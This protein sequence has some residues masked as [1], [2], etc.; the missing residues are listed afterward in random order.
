MINVK[1][2]NRSGPRPSL[3]ASRDFERPPISFGRDSTCS[4]VL[5]DPHKHISRFHVEIEEVDGVYW[6]GVTS[7]VN[8]VMVAGRRYGP[9]T[10]LV[11]KS[12]DTFEIGEYE[13]QVSLPEP[14]GGGGEAAS[15][16]SDLSAGGRQPAAA[17]ARHRIATGGRTETCAGIRACSGRAS[18][19]GGR[20]SAPG[21]GDLRA[22]RRSQ[23]ARARTTRRIARAGRGTAG[24]HGGGGVAVQ[25]GSRR[26]GGAHAARLR[27]D[28]ARRGGRNHAP[29]HRP[30]GGTQ[31]VARR[32]PHHGRCGRQQPA[33][34]DVRPAG[35]DGVPLRSLGADRRLPRPGAGGW[36]C[37]RGPARARIRR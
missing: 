2:L 37:L 36:R 11:L 23:G 1:I 21:G 28:P 29:P 22:D 20:G 18:S 34:A 32:G 3:Y 33:E 5:D 35:G 17:R 14:G 31:G 7:K 25:G 4:V 6:M 10:R 8:P 30:L 12:G 24:L 19:G 26:P 27:R 13:V 9:G 16:G 15:P